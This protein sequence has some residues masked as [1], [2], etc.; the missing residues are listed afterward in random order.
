MALSRCSICSHPRRDEID[1]DLVRGAGLRDIAER[2]QVGRMSVQRHRP[3]LDHTLLKAHEV[4]EVARAD[5][6]LGELRGLT[7]RA[8]GLLARAERAG[9]LR[10]AATAI[11]E[12]RGC[13]ELLGRLSGELQSNP[14]INITLA[15]SWIALRGRIV[16]GLQAYPEARL[17]LA[18]V[19]DQEHHE[20]S[21]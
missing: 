1:A 18:A 5:A 13:L 16:A 14:V 15:P 8:R 3:H 19:I 9:D 7:D 12:C 17:A 20:P 6:L 11:R 2:F 21:E 4:G 10:G